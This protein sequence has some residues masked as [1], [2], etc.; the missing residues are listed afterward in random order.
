MLKELLKPDILKLVEA[1]DWEALRD[2]LD[3]WPPQEVADLLLHLRKTERILLFRVLPRHLAADVFAELEFDRQD[4]LIRDLSDEETKQLLA[5]LHPDDR[6]QLLG[7]L[8]GQATQ[9]LLNLLD[10]EDLEQSRWLLGYP[11][12]S[13]GRL[14]T[15][16]YV[17]VHPEETI[18]QAL[19]HIRA[20]GRDTEAVNVVFVVDDEWILLDAIDLRRFILT[21]PGQT[22]TD[23]MTRRTRSIP[24]TAGRAQAVQMIRRYDMVALPVVDTG[25]VLLGVVT[26]DDVLDVAEQEATEDFHRVGSV[27]PIRTSIREATVGFMFRKRIGWLMALVFMNIFSGAGLAF[28]EETITAVVALLFFLPLLIGSGGNAGSQSAT[29]MVRALAT[30]DVTGADWLRLL[31]KEVGVALLLG[32]GLA[33]GAATISYFRAPEVMVVVAMAMVCIVITGSLIGMSLPF[34]L[35]RAGLDPATASAPLITS[36]SDISGVVIYF[37]IATWY[38]GLH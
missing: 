35:T 3:Y 33:A 12:G 6:T 14:M 11:E 8:P 15:P 5:E 27:E 19:N 2:S 38:L 9:R 28:F 16:H 18:E 36:L 7:E 31:G 17:A 10:P 25:G 37:S 26:V 23:I 13:V 1:R 4:E 30:G 32:G 20:H 22:V 34:L 24:A 21:P 29:L